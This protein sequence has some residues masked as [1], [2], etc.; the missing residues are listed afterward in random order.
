MNNSEEDD[1][2]EWK[3]KETTAKQEPLP[4]THQNYN[5]SLQNLTID[6]EHGD[7]TNE[8]LNITTADDPVFVLFMAEIKTTR[9]TWIEEISIPSKKVKET[10]SPPKR[11]EVTELQDNTNMQICL[12]NYSQQ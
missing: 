4:R 2:I 8:P 9:L 11:S 10:T 5:G 1:L 6:W 3:F 12:S 7:V